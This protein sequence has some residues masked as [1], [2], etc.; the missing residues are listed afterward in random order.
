MPIEIFRSRH[1]LEGWLKALAVTCV[2]SFLSI[3]IV[4]HAIARPS[5][6]GMVSIGVL[7]DLSGPLSN[8][9]IASLT[10]ARRAVDDVNR[11]GIAT[12]GKTIR[13]LVTDTAGNP[14]KLLVGASRFTGLQQADVLI[15]PTTPSLVRTL[16]GFASA[17]KIPLILTAGSRPV[18]PF[19]GRN[20]SWIFSVS[21]GIIPEIKALYHSL[22][23]MRL[24]KIGILTVANSSG[25]QAALWLQ[26]YAPE[27]HLRIVGREGFGQ[28]DTDAMLQLARLQEKGAQIIIA[29]G[30]RTA[31]RVLLRS[32]RGIDVPI[33]VPQAML[34]EELLA[35][36]PAPRNRLWAIASPVLL[37]PSLPSAHPCSLAVERFLESMQSGGPPLSIGRL[38]AAGKAWDAIHLTAMAISNTPY[39]TTSGIKDALETM[40]NDY[41]GVMGIFHPSERNHGGLLP[42]SLLVVRLTPAGWQ[43]IDGNVHIDL[44]KDSRPNTA[45][46]P[47]AP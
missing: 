15:G 36:F 12:G 20:I 24:S 25:D 30:G 4:S 34:S 37:G 33:V 6:P 45:R 19:R 9:G 44:T 18:I 8:Q 3:L 35:N 38:L 16:S 32:L 2:I 31:G 1:Q 46:S 23:L 14:G 40:E 13:L 27:Y 39:I 22:T 11:Q 21:P 47:M 42:S 10:A 43:R 28:E 41:I 26:G 7:W 29:W 5:I 17:H